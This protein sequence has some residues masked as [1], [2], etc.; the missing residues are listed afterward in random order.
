M[1][2]FLPYDILLYY[3]PRREVSHVGNPFE[4]L[5]I[6]SR[7]T[8][9]ELRSAYRNLARRWHP[10]RFMEGPER[11]WAL[12]HMT[13]INAAYSECTAL[14]KSGAPIPSSDSALDEI[15]SLIQSRRYSEAR[16]RLLRCET[17]CA[18]WNY[19]FGVVLE[20]QGEGEKA[21]TYLN[22]AV[23]QAPDN[24]L[25]RTT[26]DSA[27]KPTVHSRVTDLFQTLRRKR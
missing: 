16:R 11:E 1:T 23:R 3:D 2:F 9:E 5:G 24:A 4:T 10:D 22:L 18:R 25:Y 13:E 17:R 7:C 15:S 27:Q 12:Q 6:S 19:L 8:Q 26:R 21:L 20:K 14:L